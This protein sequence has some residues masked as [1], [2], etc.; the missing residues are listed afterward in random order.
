MKFFIISLII[1]FSLSVGF[2]NIAQGQTIDNHPSL[3]EVTLQVQI[4][5]SEGHLVAYY[6][7]NQKY[8]GNIVILHE[9]LDTKE[10]KTTIQK[11]GKNLQVIE[12]EQ[13]GTYKTTDIHTT[14]HLIY[15]GQFGISVFTDGY[16][17]EPGDSYTASWKIVRL[18]N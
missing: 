1:L 14:F 15:K 16:L 11:E 18:L 17:S 6:E 2:V 10:N 9:Y 13:S 5:D 4:R 8:V 3:V 12:W 7:P